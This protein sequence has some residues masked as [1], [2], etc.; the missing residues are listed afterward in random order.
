MT[1]GR[2]PKNK[3]NIEEVKRNKVA[4]QLLGTPVP[5]LGHRYPSTA[6]VMNSLAIV[7]S[8]ISDLDLDQE[9]FK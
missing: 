7:A 8:S 3:T 6:V 9:L 4:V 5:L 1:M 2:K